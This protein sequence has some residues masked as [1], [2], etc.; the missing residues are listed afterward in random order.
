MAE[1]I[2]KNLIVPGSTDVYTFDATTFA[3]K[4]EEQWENRITGNVDYLGG[5]HNDT[6][7]QAKTPDSIGDFVRVLTGFPVPAA[8]SYTGVSFDVHAGDLLICE[9]LATKDAR[10]KWSFVHGEEGNLITHKHKVTAAGTVSQPIFTGT[11]INHKHSFSGTQATITIKHTPSGTVTI[12]SHSPN[13]GETANYTPSGTVSKPTF[14]GT[15]A[16]TGDNTTGASVASPTHTHSIN[17]S[18]NVTV[19]SFTPSGSIGSTVTIPSGKTAN[20]TPAGKVALPALTA[21][22]EL[23]TT[24]VATVTDAGTAYSM[25]D[26]KVEK[27]ADA[28]ASFVQK[29]VKFSVNAEDESLSLDYTTAASDAAFYAAAVTAAGAVTYT[30]PKLSGALP[31]FGTSSVAV[32]T[33]A[34]AK[35]E[36]NGEATF[37]GTGAV[38][39]TTI[40]TETTAATVTQPVFTAAFTGTKKSVTPTVATTEDAQAPNGTITVATETITPVVTKKTSTVTVQ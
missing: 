5:V 35:A 23:N 32:A 25:T 14:T 27:A 29:G 9:V 20:Y 3:G 10:A 34:T 17:I 8:A 4:T 7:L 19:N 15:A 13:T 21:S 36:Y 6:E 22:V 12:G 24:D 28:T 31:T 18:G 40:A 1:K 39:G 11:K 26:G 2:I 33:G 30:A 16:N 38:L 37:T